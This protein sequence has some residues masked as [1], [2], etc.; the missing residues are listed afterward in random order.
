MSTLT[1]EYIE[2]EKLRNNKRNAR[3]MSKGGDMKNSTVLDC[4]FFLCLGLGMVGWIG[5]AVYMWHLAAPEAW[6]WISDVQ[7]AR[8][9]R[10]LIFVAG[11]WI[12][13]W[14]ALVFRIGR[15]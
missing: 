14:A 12:G 5:G 10:L 9:G 7:I 15:T 6:R 11:A 13:V 3:R 4:L 2:L 8:L 1:V